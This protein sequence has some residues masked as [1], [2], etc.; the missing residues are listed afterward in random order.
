MSRR[1]ITFLSCGALAL[2]GGAIIAGCGDD[3]EEG[4]S[5]ATPASTGEAAAPAEEEG[6]NVEISMKG[7]KMV[8]DTATAKVG[9]K[10]VWTNNDGYPH[11]VT[12]KSGE[13]FKSDNFATGTFEFTP[14]KA[15]EIDYV[16]TIHSGQRGTITVTQ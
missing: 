9:Q 13:T 14:T 4:G 1:F 3:D 7:N 8:P 2:G 15:G 6:A 11:N 5:S 16:C 12:A 10:I